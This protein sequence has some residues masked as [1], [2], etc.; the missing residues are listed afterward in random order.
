MLEV[1]TDNAEAIS[2]YLGHGFKIVV[3]IKGY[4]YGIKDAYVMGR[5]LG[6][7]RVSIHG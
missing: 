6:S 2:F 4:Y 1:A 3:F 7:K 5:I